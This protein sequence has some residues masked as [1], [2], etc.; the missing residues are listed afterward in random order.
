MRPRKLA[1]R[2]SPGW[3]L[4]RN[5]TCDSHYFRATTRNLINVFTNSGNSFLPGSSDYC[6]QSS[7]RRR[8]Y[9]GETGTGRAT[10]DERPP[11]PPPVTRGSVTRWRLASLTRGGYVAAPTPRLETSVNRPSWIT[12]QNRSSKL[13]ILRRIY[14]SKV[15]CFSLPVASASLLTQ[16]MESWIKRWLQLC[17]PNA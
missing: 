10:S 1:A 2:S 5:F 4:R 3:R 9:N 14:L 12:F 7:A 16:D 17:V 13:T 11:P 15:T 6:K 8:L